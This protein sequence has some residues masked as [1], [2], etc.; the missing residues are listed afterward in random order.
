V[1][2]KGDIGVERRHLA[3]DER[4][5]A[6]AQSRMATAAIDAY[7]GAGSGAT[8]S[9]LDT[10]SMSGAEDQ[11]VYLGVAS[12]NLDNAIAAFG[13]AEQHTEATESHLS[14]DETTLESTLRQVSTARSEAQT[15]VLADQ[16]LLS[17]VKHNLLTLVLQAEQ[18]REAAEELAAE[19]AQ[20]LQQKEEEEKQKESH[21]PPPPVIPPPVTP[22]PITS[23]PVGSGGYANPLRA[24]SALS[25]E[26][27]DQGV[28]F[29]GFGPI[30]AIG[31]GVVLNTYNAGWPGGT[32]IIYQLTDGPASGLFVYA[33]EDIDP[34]VSIG[35]TV[36]PNTVLGQMYEGSSGIET[37]WADGSALGES[38]ASE[39]GQFSG[40]N[41]TAF[42]ANFS[43]L[44]ESV[45]A[46][47]GILQNDPPTGGLPAGWPEW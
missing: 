29:S 18:R 14:A 45:G 27:I 21:P 37:G 16:S 43:E 12:N 36:T 23:P 20:A 1:V 44:L 39:Y 32:I 25:P 19:E 17:H 11:Q 13:T 3:S 15:A 5:Q 34:E 42:G 28:D 41:S 4:S 8:G 38:M 7:V 6:T 40:A 35:E 33:A 26:R 31:D 10:P 47:G 9:V 22:P 30:Y 24:I 46:P 2:I